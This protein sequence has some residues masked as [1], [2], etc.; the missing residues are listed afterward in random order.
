M[1][2]VAQLD[3]AL[4]DM[5]AIA[6]G[7]STGHSKTPKST[8]EANGGLSS[9]GDK[10]ELS[11]TGDLNGTPAAG[12][13]KASKGGKK[14]LK[15]WAKDDESS[16]SESSSDNA[17]KG[18]DEDEDDDD[19]DK[20]VEDDSEES[21]SESESESTSGEPPVKKGKTKKSAS[22]AD[23]MKSDSSVGPVVDVSPFIEGLVDQVSDADTRL[24]KSVKLMHE[25]QRAFQRA[26]AKVLGALAKS[27]Q[28][29]QERL[30]GIENA[31]VGARKSVLTKSEV[32]ERFTE[33][34]A[35]IGSDDFE[36]SKP[37]VLDAL[38]ELAKSHQIEPLEVSRYE[39]TDSMELGTQ[40]KVEE[41][42]TKSAR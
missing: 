33:N 14:N 40:R 27:I 1:A 35:G 36:F 21:S 2:T 29:V 39:T 7:G 30:G 31:P 6:K 22:L 20:A 11:V 16:S 42:L 34:G 23:L 26:E 8:T 37:Q 38:V 10:G 17:R 3:K 4:S 19:I 41:F 32:N 24:R 15:Q 13:A 28:E 18:G 25:E 12:V 5:E 9:E